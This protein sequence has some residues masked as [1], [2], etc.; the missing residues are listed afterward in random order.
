M[1]HLLI[2]YDLFVLM[3]GFAALIFALLHAFRSRAPGALYFSLLYFLFTAIVIFTV[4]DKYLLMNVRG[5]SLRTI[6]ILRGVKVVTHFALVYTVILYLQDELALRWRSQIALGLLFPTVFN[7]ALVLLPGGVVFLE[8]ERRILFGTGYYLASGCS[9]LLFTYAISLGIASV[10]KASN[11]NTRGFRLG[12]IL[13]AGVGYFETIAGFVANIIRTYDVLSMERGGFLL[14]SVPY[15]L[16]G[17]FL[18][19]FF[20]RSG[21]M[22]DSETAK[23]SEAF[24]ER[25]GITAREAEIVL[26]VVRGKTN[27]E[28]ADALCIS[29]ATVKTHLHNVFR[30]AGVRSRYGLIHKARGR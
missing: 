14:S 11:V 28:I 29:L 17:V 20:A 6:F 30:K 8:E 12:L 19:G 2:A 5:V 3:I 22:S 13:F 16:Y 18:I 26:L 25:S 24:S 10:L 15:A 21:A 27:G 4:V 1:G 7:A 23:L 9:L